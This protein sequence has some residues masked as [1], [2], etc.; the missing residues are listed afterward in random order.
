MKTLLATTFV[1]LTLGIVMGQDQHLADSLVR[2]YKSGNYEGNELHI[3]SVIAEEETN[4][5]KHL[6]FSELLIS[7]APDTAVYYLQIGYLQKGNALKYKGDN[8]A[9]L[10]AYFKSLEFANQTSDET[11]IGSLMISI[12]GT[13]TVM[14]NSSNAQTY[15]NRG[16]VILRKGKDSVKIGTALLNAGDDYFNSGKLDSAFMFTQESEVIFERIGFPLGRAYSLGNLGMIYAEKEQDIQAEQNINKAIDILEKLE[17]Y[18]PISVYLTFIS[19]IYERK[20][21]LPLALEY[22]KRSLQL[23]STYGLKEQIS[24]ASLKLS[25]LYEKLGNEQ[26]ALRHY[27]NYIIYRDSIINLE[28]VQ[29]IA[30]LRTDFEV[31]QKQV[32][33]DLLNQQKK[34]QR[35]IGSAVVLLIGIVAFGL[36]RRNTFV[37]RTN[38]IIEAEKHRSDK[39]LLNILPAEIAEELKAKGKA[40]AREFKNVSILFTDFKG[41]TEASSQLSAQDLVSELNTCFEEFDSIMSKYGI[42]KIKTIGDAYMAA[43]GLPVPSKDSVRNTVLAA[44]EMQDY[45]LRRKMSMDGKGKHAFQMRAGI[46]TGPVVAGI[47]GT[48]KFQYDIWG[49]A[50]NTSSRLESHGSIGKVNI[51]EQTFNLIKD[52]PVFRFERRGKIQAK[53]K[54][55][56]EM[57]FV[58]LADL[59]N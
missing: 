46:H 33:V 43:G 47:V 10:Q 42:E 19:D 35:I 17:D 4:P 37:R 13:Y 12:A 45:I 9:A 54:G 57:Y 41:F 59:N 3:L 52:D 36:Y 20:N 15:F 11:A 6:E 51:S 22:A 34:N 44:L 28:N 25:E 5:D 32:E 7:K 48:K 50:V 31:S 56:I 26:A 55:E 18:Y 53:G 30:N 40:E 24:E 38:R 16:L 29:Q 8:A 23:A 1:L 27:K 39:L 2:E 14:G 21:D 49:D 58:S